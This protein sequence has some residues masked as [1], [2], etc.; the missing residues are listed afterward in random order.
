MDD[1]AIT[2]L[3][4]VLIFVG[5]PVLILRTNDRRRTA[6]GQRDHTPATEITERQAVEQRL[7][8]PD[9]S[10]VER[11]LRRPV[12]QALRDLYSDHSL[13]TRRDL[14]YADDHVISTFEPLDEH[15]IL[16]ATHW[17]GFEAVLIA[18]TDFGDAVY[19]R[20]GAAEADALYLTHHDGGDTE[21]LAESVAQLLASLTQRHEPQR[22]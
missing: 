12:P 5:L 3:A 16:D 7:L 20:S 17:L 15:R 14:T 8:S 18:S 21:V 4:I 2:V 10:C 1:T 13:I 11:H 19:L 9:W 6:R 22:E